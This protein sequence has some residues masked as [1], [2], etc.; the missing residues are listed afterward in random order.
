MAKLRNKDPEI[1]KI[2]KPIFEENDFEGEQPQIQGNSDNNKKEK[3]TY[4]DL[5]AKGH[6]SE[7]D[8]SESS[9]NP[10]KDLKKIKEKIKSKL[11]GV[12]EEVDNDD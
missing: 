6:E 12:P 4:G 7:Q 11:K 8:E 9:E 5:I 3:L 1:Y 2:D 10:A